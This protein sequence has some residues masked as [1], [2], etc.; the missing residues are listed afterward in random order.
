MPPIVPP[1]CA[2]AQEGEKSLTLT[3]PATTPKCVMVEFL[4]Q[5]VM[6]FTKMAKMA[7]FGAVPAQGEVQRAFRGARV[8]EHIRAGYHADASVREAPRRR[9]R[10]AD[11]RSFWASFSPLVAGGGVEWLAQS[12]K[13]LLVAAD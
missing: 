4:L 12:L 9:I 3:P 1:A 11:A 8:D 2:G 10:P 13:K 5:C 6:V 7:T